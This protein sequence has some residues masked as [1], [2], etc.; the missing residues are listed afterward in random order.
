MSNPTTAIGIDFGGTSIKTAV[1]RQG[2][3]VQRGETI[4]PQAFGSADA[5]IAALIHAIEALRRAEPDV[6]GVG[7]GLPGFIDSVNG[8]VHTLTNV[9]GWQDVPFCKML[10]ERTGLVAVIENDANAMAVGE[11]RYGAAVGARHAVCITLGT[12]V[13]GALIL[14]GRLYRGAK[15][16]AGEIGH[17]SID[18]R[19]ILGP[20]GNPGGLE[21]YV[22]NAQI[23][24]RAV[25]LYRAAGAVKSA[26]DCAPVTL[27]RAAQSGDKIALELWKAVGTEIGAALASV[28]WILNPDTVVIGGGIAKAG[29]L[30]IEPIRSTIIERTNSV[31]HEGLRIV[32]AVLGNDAGMIGNAVLAIEA[33]RGN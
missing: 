10:R 16:A 8:I 32:P 7:V 22:G 18:Y 12:G 27:A 5:L 17:M 11:W 29:E 33:A 21:E 15:L 1:V 4:D 6:V 31:F 2:R 25:E 9:P 24:A 26:E 23:T 3:I 13:G 19:G 30:V 20:Y 14:D 28:V